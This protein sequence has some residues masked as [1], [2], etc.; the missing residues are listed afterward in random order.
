M[1]LL[2]TDHL[3]IL[4]RG[5]STA[6]PLQMRLGQVPVSE[7]DT[8]IINYEEQMRG[9]LSQAAQANTP[10]KII[11]AYALLQTHVE[12]FRDFL[13]L[14]F[15]R[16]ASNYFEG[17]RKARLG[18]G[19]KD[20]RIAAVCLAHDA[21]LLTRNLRDFGKVPGLRAEDWST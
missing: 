17:L 2:D 10:E 9:W 5:G 4:E 21:T 8:T 15:D 16:A 18:V 6:L 3:T 1:W 14:P 19:T 11:N 7:V 20:L 13:I 12:T